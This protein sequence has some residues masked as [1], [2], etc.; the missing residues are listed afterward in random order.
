MDC[1]KYNK[2]IREF[3]TIIS[4]KSALKLNKFGSKYKSYASALYNN[5]PKEQTP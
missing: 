4:T 3:I 1:D 5:T 2:S